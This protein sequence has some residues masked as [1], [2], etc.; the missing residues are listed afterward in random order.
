[1]TYAEA[2]AKLDKDIAGAKMSNMQYVVLPLDVAESLSALCRQMQQED[3]RNDQGA[4]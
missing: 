2:H 3:A 1:M 4:Y